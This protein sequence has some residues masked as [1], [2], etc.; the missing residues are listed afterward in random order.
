MSWI[1]T[2]DNNNWIVVLWDGSTESN[3]MSEIYHKVSAALLT[4]QQQQNLQAQQS[5][6]V[7]NNNNNIV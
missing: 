3:F 6:H 4:H 2:T 5:I 7:D 1:L